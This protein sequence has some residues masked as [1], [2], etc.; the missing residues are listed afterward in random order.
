[1]RV[2]VCLLALIVGAYSAEPRAFDALTR[3]FQYDAASPL[4]VRQE[5]SWDVE[6]ARVISLSYMGKRGAVSAYLVKPAAPGKHPAILFAHDLETKRDEFLAEAIILARTEPYAV[7]LLV[8]AP[9]ARPPGWRRNFNPQI[10]DNDRDLEAQAIVDLRRGIDYLIAQGDADP[11]RIAFI[12]HGHG[13]NWGAVLASIEP[14]LSAFVLIAGVISVADVMRRDDAEWAD[15]RY[16]LGREKF[17]EYLSSIAEV[18]PVRYIGHWLGSPALLQFGRF[19]PYVPQ[20]S[21]DA[22]AKAM[23]QHGRTIFY[24]A[25]HAVNDPKALADRDAF[26]RQ[27]FARKRTQ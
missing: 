10:A 8:D 3:L 26:L 2:V 4:E 15:M 24:D 19:D 18:D 17:N 9:T 5:Q 25:G 21:A 22:F 20:D 11:A 6:G 1:M 14:R 7:S 16:T 12:G 13:A 27:Q 23:R